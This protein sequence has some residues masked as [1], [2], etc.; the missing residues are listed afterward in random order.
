MSRQLGLSSKSRVDDLL[1]PLRF[2]CL[3][4]RH[5]ITDVDQKASPRLHEAL[6]ICLWKS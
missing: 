1:V 4:A 3:P 2:V 6:P 5:T